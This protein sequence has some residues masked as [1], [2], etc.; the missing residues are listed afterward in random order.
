MS[1]TIRHSDVLEAVRRGS[2]S[3]LSELY[4][5][6]ADAVFSLAYRVTGSREDAEDVLQDVFVG[7]PRSLKS[8]DERGRFESWLK[9]VVV[10]ASAMRLR[11]A[12][13]RREQPLDESG[14]LSRRDASV[15]GVIDRLVLERAL[16]RMP[17]AMRTVFMLREIEGYSHDEIGG[18]LGISAGASATRLSRA[19][20]FL[21][22][23]LNP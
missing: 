15:S 5:A 8:Y 19:W 22:K 1:E 21:R 17:D 9:R 14:P 2:R 18:L 16:T 7:L 3:A 11:S 20:S 23:E 13:R 12:T 6:H 10:R 4:R